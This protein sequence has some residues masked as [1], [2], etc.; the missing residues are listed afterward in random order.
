MQDVSNQTTKTH[1]TPSCVL[2]AIEWWFY[3]Q[4]VGVQQQGTI[5]GDDD[6]YRRHPWILGEA[7]HFVTGP[8]GHRPMSLR[9]RP[10]WSQAQLVTGLVRNRPSKSQI[11]FITGLLK[12]VTLSQAQLVTGPCHFVTGPVGHRP[13]RSQAQ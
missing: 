9:H 1:T 8:V 4:V 3:L 12:H 6:F 2:Q 13:S 11:Y 7:C 5:N 10:S